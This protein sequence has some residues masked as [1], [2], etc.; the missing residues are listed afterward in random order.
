[1]Q[2]RA[3]PDLEQTNRSP[4]GPRPQTRTMAVFVQ[5]PRRR[6]NSPIRKNR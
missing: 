6:P 1:M 2:R 4:I 3:L 5:L